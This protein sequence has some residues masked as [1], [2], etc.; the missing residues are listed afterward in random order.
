MS[1]AFF[2]ITAADRDNL[3]TQW[4]ELAAAYC[5][6]QNLI[7]KIFA[8]ITA[9]YSRADRAYHNLGHIKALLDRALLIR[10]QLNDYDSV[11]F[12]IW[13][14]DVIY[15]TRKS[16]NEEQSAEFA[17]KA[18]SELAVPEHLRARVREMIIATK[19]HQ[20]AKASVDTEYFLDLDLSILGAHAEIYQQYSQAI[21][22]EYCWVPMF[23]YRITRKKILKNFLQRERLY[24]TSQLRAE[25][26]VQA[27]KNIAEE[28]KTI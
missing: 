15:H 18:L 8:Q 11:R 26:E 13:F 1:S 9:E 10:A 12:A 28:L 27:R 24:F 21:R 4:R 3:Q 22:Q 23:L 14:H 25:L 6:D 16:D 19:T 17:K 5:Q 2:Q 7:E 20:I